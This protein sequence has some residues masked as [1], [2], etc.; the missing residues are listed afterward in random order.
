[1]SLPAHIANG[2][3][4]MYPGGLL[5]RSRRWDVL[6]QRLQWYREAV[7]WCET[8]GI[9][10]YWWVLSDCGLLGAFNDDVECQ[11]AIDDCIS[12]ALARAH[13]FKPLLSPARSREAI[14]HLKTF[15]SERQKMY[16]GGI[17]E[18]VCDTEYGEQGYRIKRVK[19]YGQGE[20]FIIIDPKGRRIGSAPKLS[21][22]IA[23]LAQM[24]PRGR[25]L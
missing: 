23:I 14:A 17:V 19:L 2:V 22:A 6:V 20:I 25:V 15:R 4:E 9:A 12:G 21:E 10:E 7:M 5:Q 8:D 3:S 18:E 1:M 16:L 11:R 24:I 13:L